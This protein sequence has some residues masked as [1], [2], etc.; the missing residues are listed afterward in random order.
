M[1]K[2]HLSILFVFLL[3]VAPLSRASNLCD[4]SCDLSIDFANGGS[5]EAVDSLTLVFGNGGTLVLGAGGTI[6]TNPQPADTDFSSGGALAL[7]TG[8]SITF[9][10]GG[11]LVLGSGGN[12]DYTSMTLTVDGNITLAA[13]GGAQT[14][15]LHDNTILA[16][17]SLELNS[18]ATAGGNVTVMGSGVTIGSG[19]SIPDISGSGSINIASAGTLT[20]GS[21]VYDNTSP[22][23][24]LNDINLDLTSPTLDITGDLTVVTLT[25]EGLA[26][27]EGQSLPTSDGNTC[28]VTNGE[29]VTASGVKYV[30]NSEGELAPAAVDNGGALNWY[31]LLIISALLSLRTHRIG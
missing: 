16:V 1:K 29:C 27:L 3:V 31:V 13:V 19:N 24:T 6:N 17:S 2:L 8:D 26:F 28:T 11:S 14:V 30:V 15:F 23:L 9:G 12:I 18:E 10:P 20:V 21:L 22:V 7:N 4:A 5:I 25:Q